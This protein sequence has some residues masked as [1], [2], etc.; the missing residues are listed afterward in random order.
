MPDT[1][2][3]PFTPPLSDVQT[4]GASAGKV[5]RVDYRLGR[6]DYFLWNVFHQLTMPSL[7]LVAL[8]V[9]VF[10]AGQFTNP[11]ALRIFI[12]VLVYAFIFAAQFAFSAIVIALGRNRT[13]LTDYRTELRDEGI[14][15]ETEWATSLHYWRGVPRIVQRPGFVAVYVNSHAAH[16]I[17]NRAFPS[18]THRDQFLAVARARRAEASAPRVKS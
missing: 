18:S 12:F 16:I 13:L 17:P 10:F 5:F 7:Q 14:L 2:S 3:N 15:F 1:P 4:H 8:A 9:A 6:R 11:S